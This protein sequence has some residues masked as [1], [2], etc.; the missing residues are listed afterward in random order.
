MCV[1]LRDYGYSAHARDRIACWTATHGTPTGCPYLDREDE[2]DV[3][4]VYVAGLEPVPFTGEA[5]DRDTS[6]IFDAEMLARGDHPWPIVGG[7]DDD[8]EFDPDAGCESLPGLPDLRD[9]DD[10]PEGLPPITGGSPEAEP[11][12]PTNE[13]LQDFAQWSDAVAMKRWYDER[14]GLAAFNADRPESE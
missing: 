2:Q 14:G 1:L 12:E 9:P 4:E 5:W 10:W 3:T 7:P 8:R 11:F 13:D 6:V